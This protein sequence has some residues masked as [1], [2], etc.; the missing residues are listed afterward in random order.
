MIAEMS[1]MGL[2]EQL[3]S[4]HREW[5]DRFDPQHAKAWTN[6]RENHPE[7][8]LCEAAVRDIM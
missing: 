5:L 7:A 1:I 2:Q 8:A 6:N 3:E 4:A